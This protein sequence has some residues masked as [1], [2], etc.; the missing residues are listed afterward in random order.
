MSLQPGP[1][2]VKKRCCGS[3]PRCKRCAVVL[4]RLSSAGLAERRSK[5]HYVVLELVPKKRLKKA[6]A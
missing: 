1:I 4:K 3:R 6:R 2:K 5:R